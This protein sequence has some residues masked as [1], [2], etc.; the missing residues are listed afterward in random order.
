MESMD[1][2]ELNYIEEPDLLSDTKF[3]ILYEIYVKIEKSGA[4]DIKVDDLLQIF[5]FLREEMKQDELVNGWMALLLNQQKK[6]EVSRYE[7]EVEGERRVARRAQ[8]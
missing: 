2:P 6:R 7:G 5:Q 1:L 4:E 8:E 3:P